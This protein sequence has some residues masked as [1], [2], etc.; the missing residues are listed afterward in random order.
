MQN[1]Q[2]LAHIQRLA[3]QLQS[4]L[5]T[6]GVIDRAVGIVMSRTGGTEGEAMARLRALSRSEPQQL[7]VVA[8]Q[9]V[10]EAAGR[11]EAGHQGD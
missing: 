9:I 1:A 8:G 10:E 7:E 4:A 3:A 5:Q 6:R 2:V 11:T